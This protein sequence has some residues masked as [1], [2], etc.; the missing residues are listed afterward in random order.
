MI[1]RSA[2]IAAVAIVMAT[3]ALAQTNTAASDISVW[4]VLPVASTRAD[5]HLGKADN[6]DGAA[7]APMAT[8][9]RKRVGVP[10][11]NVSSTCRAASD[12]QLSDSQNY[13]TC[14]K[15]ERQARDQAAKNW[16]S[17][18]PA[19]RA[20]CTAEATTGGS[21]SYVDLFEC[22]EMAK[23]ALQLNTKGTVPNTTPSQTTNSISNK[24]A[25]P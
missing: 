11:L 18:S 3:P 2:L 17:Y 25:Q 5:R 1:R 6:R 20:R 22:M 23:W 24:G 10:M 8:R 13:D 7:V 16:P 4:R 9:N 12:L 21:P 14:M 19:I 15:D